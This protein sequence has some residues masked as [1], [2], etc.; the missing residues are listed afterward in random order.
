M[1]QQDVHRIYEY[2][3]RSVQGVATEDEIL[4][5]LGLTRSEYQRACRQLERT[6]S[7]EVDITSSQRPYIQIRRLSD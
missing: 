3:G 7:I 2:L 6:G 5:A 1:I 4:E